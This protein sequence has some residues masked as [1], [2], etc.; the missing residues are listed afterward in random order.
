MTL[1]SMRMF[2][3]ALTSLI[4]LGA[5]HN[6]AMSDDKTVSARPTE[7]MII[8]VAQQFVLEHFK[9]QPAEY[10]DVAFDIATIH[11][12][13]DKGYWAVV[14]GFMAD[15]G[16][17]NYKPH[18][19]GIAMRLICPEHEKMKCWQMEKLVIDQTIILNN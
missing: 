19:F 5:G 17:K 7:S 18:A 16:G 12:Q 14:G 15:A 6:H 13:P 9:R 10:F 4:C 8:G 11:A 3:I 1:S 2:L